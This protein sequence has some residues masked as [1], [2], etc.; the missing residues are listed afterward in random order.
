MN[1]YKKYKDLVIKSDVF[2]A[3]ITYSEALEKLHP[4]IN[5]FESQRKLLDNKFYKRL[6]RDIIEG[7]IMPPVTIAFV[8]K[9]NKKISDYESYINHNIENA[10][11]LDGIQRLNTLKRTEDKDG[12]DGTRVMFLNI[13][14]SPSKDKLLYR[15]ITL[16]NGQKPMTPRHQIEILTQELFS[17]DDLNIIVQTEKE[18][19]DNPII[20]SFNLGD[21]SRG[22]LA[23]LTN[24]AHNE[25]SKIIGEKMD[26][27]LVGRILDSEITESPIE[28][29]DVLRIIDNLSYQNETNRKWLQTSNNLI[30]FSVGIKK[31]FE[32]F[33][34]LNPKDF[35][36][37]IEKFEEAFKAI[38]PSKVNL[39][40]IR[41][42][43]SENF[44]EFFPNYQ[45]KS[46][47]EYI[48]TFFELSV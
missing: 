26:Q 42:D 47:D 15:M 28:F 21:I 32:T 37:E 27:I 1:I 35:Q 25:N 39:G 31:S 19:A 16:N 23:F 46:I 14:I 13:I 36:I 30:G 33:I 4:L 12:F 7:C 17:F 6:E 10:Y 2:I 22:Y 5:R 48:E 18:K 34:G 20:G 29:Y 40:K 43:F 44:I 9:D 41:R 8:N 45:E 24:N 38:N 3:D 11:I